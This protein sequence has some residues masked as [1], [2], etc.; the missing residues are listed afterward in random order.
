MKCVF[1]ISF[2][3][4]FFIIEPFLVSG[5]ACV[6]C[7]WHLLDSSIFFFIPYSCTPDK[8]VLDWTLEQKLL[9]YPGMSCLRWALQSASLC[10]GTLPK[11][12]RFVALRNCVWRWLAVWNR[13]LHSNQTK[14]NGGARRSHC[15]FKK[16]NVFFFC[17]CCF[18]IWTTCMCINDIEHKTNRWSKHR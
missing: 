4:F 8:E 10:N 3:L 14:Q 12:K 9:P 2:K 5:E 15:R 13:T 11:K 16:L 6:P 7:L 18:C 17:C 1:F